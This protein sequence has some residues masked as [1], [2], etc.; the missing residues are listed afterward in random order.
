MFEPS[1]GSIAFSVNAKRVSVAVSPAQRLAK[2]LREELGLTGTK[3]GCDAGDCGACTVLIDGAPA[4]ACLVALGQVDGREVVTVEGIARHTRAGDRLRAAFARTGAAQ[5]GICTPGMLVAACALLEKNPAPSE[6]QVL[7][8]LGGVLCRCT[9]YRKIIDAVMAAGRELPALETPRAGAAVGARI[10]R[11]D[12][13]AKLDG[14]EVFG[15]DYAPCDSLLARAVRSPYHRARFHFGDL[16]AFAAA[17]DGI[18]GVFTAR[19]VPGENRFGVLPQYVDQPAFAEEEARF[20]GEAVALVVG[21]P[22]VIESLDLAKFPV[23][24]Q[25]LPALTTVAAALASG[26]PLVHTARREN[27]LVRGRVVRGD[28]DAALQAPDVV[29]AEGEFE[30]GFIEHAYIE[31]EAGFACRVGDRIEI[32]AC[33][34]SPYMD[35]DGVA[36]LLG[37]APERVR[38]IPTAVGGGFG[39]KL[40]LSLQPMIAVAAWHLRCP[41]RMVYSRTESMMS[42]TK[43]H[44]ARMRMR[45]GARADGKLVAIDF[46][47]DFNTG[48]YASWGPTVAGR[49][50]VHASGPYFVP[51]YRALTRA[52]HTHLVPSGAF[53]GFGVPQTVI[54]QE[55]IFDQLADRLNIDRLEFRIRNALEAHTPTGTGQIL[56]GGV[57][58]RKCFEALRP[59]WTEAR[60]AAAEFNAQSKKPLRRGM[61]VAGMWYGCGNTALPNP[62]TIRAG[63]KPDGRIALHQGAVDIGQG[64][65][66]VI[67]QIFADAMRAPLERI[68]LI[69]AD[70]DLTPDAGKTSAS[71]QTF[72]SGSAAHQAGIELR[73]A[74]LRWANGIA[75]HDDASISFEP[76]LVKIA[77]GDMRQTIDLGRVPVDRWGYV[78]TREATFDPPV[79][80]LD[81][82]GQGVPYAAYGFGAHL[83]EV[84]VDMELG[85]VR[86]L[87]I[88]AAHDVGRAINPTLIEGQIE[89]GVAQGIGLALMEEFFPGRGENLHDYLIPS[90][91][92]VP[93]IESILIEDPAPVG[94]LGVKGIGEQALIPTAPAILN[95]I[96]DAAGIRIRKVPA[97]PDRVRA[98]ILAAAGDGDVTRRN[99]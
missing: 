36:R 77:Y 17:H 1:S 44:P 92:D 26:A 43:R 60:A 58:I 34:Q 68:D 51:H 73:R 88:T 18:A 95:A 45:A 69:S 53:R 78:V 74:I 49:V 40:D 79:T 4:C 83:A 84:E 50:P 91:G 3:V 13:P 80:T 33:T 16:S 22:R 19:D 41:V 27:V 6:G 32:Q 81:S 35:R 65:N 20:R 89:G 24:W 46:S 47:A 70:T 52:V 62:S 64:S 93:P 38:I 12:G 28:V 15:A 55:Q 87:K 42:T 10:A 63:L 39:S 11:I 7:D 67:T 66:T 86:V 72:V 97:T 94:P 59:R 14:S 8:A 82:N 30:T 9:G 57:G 71:R 23:Q 25:E 85:L 29:V 61:G 54:A 56:G 99:P 31:P 37:I 21:D 5:C 96:H 90:I 76:G 2:V 48:A 98:A 75:A